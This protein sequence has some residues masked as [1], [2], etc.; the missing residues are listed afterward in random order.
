MSASPLVAVCMP[1]FCSVLLTYCSTAYQM[2]F[3]SHY[4]HGMPRKALLKLVHYLLY[5]QVLSMVRHLDVHDHNTLSD[6]VIKM[7][8]KMGL[9]ENNT[10]T[11]PLQSCLMC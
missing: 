5:S 11:L 6:F 4:S 9:H 7:M 8:K 10:G 1:R 3:T 2:L